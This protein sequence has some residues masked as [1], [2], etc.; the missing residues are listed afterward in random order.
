M[1]FIEIVD[2]KIENVE[3]SSLFIVLNFFVG[4]RYSKGSKGV[5]IKKP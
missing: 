3:Y 1:E 5:I 4:P 2:K